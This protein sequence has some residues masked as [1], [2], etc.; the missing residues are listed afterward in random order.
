[1]LR[2]GKEDGKKKYFVLESIEKRT[3]TTENL[4]AVILYTGQR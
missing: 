3:A 4:A 2:V 1:M